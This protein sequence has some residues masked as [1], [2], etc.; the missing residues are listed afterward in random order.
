MMQKV[1]EAIRKY[2]GFDGFL[3]LQEEAIASVLADRDS[4]VVAPTGG[5]KS[6]CYQAP[7]VVMDGLAVVI[8]PLI[9]LMK[10]Q[11]DT[12]I[13]NGVR[14]ARIDSTQTPEE[15]SD[16]M[17]RLRQGALDLL[18]VS[19]ERLLMNGFLD[20]VRSARVAF[21]AVDESHCVS[22]W[23]HDFRPEYRRLNLLREAL[24]GVAVHA[25]TATAT[26]RVRED[27]ARQLELRDPE[28]LVGSFFRPNLVYRVARRTSLVAQVTDVIDRHPGR[29]GIVYCIRRKDVDALCAELCQ[30]GHKAAPYHAGLEDEERKA[31][32]ERFINDDVQVIVATVAFGMGID[33]PDV[34]FVVHAGAPKSLEH[35]QQETGRAGRDGL[36]A[37]CLL[38]HGPGDFVT[39]RF[40][41]D[42]SEMA[43]DAREVALTKLHDMQGYAGSVSCR[44]AA[45]VGYFGQSLP[46][47]NGDGCGACDACLGEIETMPQALVTAQK[48]LSCV[49]RLRESWGAG[50]VVKVLTGASDKR[51][52]ERGHD[53]LTTYGLLKGHKQ[54]TV[55]DWVEQLAGQGFLERRGEFGVLGVT[56]AGWRVIRGEEE[57]ILTAPAPDRKREPRRRGRVEVQSWEGVDEGLFE[58]LRTTRLEI[59]RARHVP[60]YVIAHDATLR[61]MARLRPSS[62]EG[63]MDVSGMGKRKV[64]HYGEAFLEVLD[65]YCREN[66]LSRDAVSS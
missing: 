22:M 39:W 60:P 62:L 54:T 64:G 61:D 14:A 18:Y 57:P 6:L 28:I 46:A 48:V 65:A 13:E 59:A 56:E 12:L 3:P 36:E 42:K 5:G 8:S 53:T 17:A 43:D 41:L 37:D 26:S 11:V 24:P 66:G 44:H 40:I 21:V 27:I 33:K 32:Q 55:R 51:L 58:A 7:A 16:A 10:D 50:H 35:Y 23:G 1:R 47:S 25:Y 2:W 15:R 31:N 9:S 30:R 4:V 34:R 29:S 19:P 63:M 20:T 49:V 45:L 38:L 52:L